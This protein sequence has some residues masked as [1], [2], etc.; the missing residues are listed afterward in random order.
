MTAALEVENLI[1]RAGK[2][3]PT[4]VEG[5]SFTAEPGEILGVVGESGSG[6][7]TLGLAILGYGR[8][9]AV[10]TGGDIRIHGRSM[11][12]SSQNEIRRLRGDAVSYM[13]QDP[14]ASLNPARHIGTQL[15][16]VLELKEG[17]RGRRSFARR[18]AAAM[19]EVHLPTEAAFLRR[20]PH[21]L[22]GG[23][24]QR[25]LLALAFLRDPSVVVLDEPT[26]GLDVTTQARVLET[27]RTMCL[28]RQTVA[29]YISHDLDVVSDLASRMLVLYGGQV[30]EFGATGDLFE[31]PRHRYTAALLASAPELDRRR[32]LV[33]IPGHAP[34]LADRHAGCAFAPRCS[35]ADDACQVRPEATAFSSAHVAHCHHPVP[36]RLAVKVMDAGRAR[37]TPS[38]PS[39]TLTAREVRANYGSVEVLHGVDL[40]VRRG[41]CVAI[42]GESGS[43]KTTLSQCLSGLHPLASGAVAVDGQ[44]LAPRARD[45][46]AVERQAIQYVFQ[47]PYGALNPRKTVRALLE[48][49]TKAFGLSNDSEGWLERVRLGRHVL[50]RRPR[51]LSGGE[52]QRVAIARALMTDPDFLICDEITSA[53]DFSIQASVINLLQSLQEETGIGIVFVTHNL[54]LVASLADRVVVMQHGE[55]VEEGATD[56]VLDTPTTAY[57]KQLLSAVPG[58]RS[59]RRSPANTEVPLIRP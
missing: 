27:V 14:G 13:P 32:P 6:K 25:V 51:Q 57:T 48:Q 38:T 50:S 18:I 19:E 40:K 4:I 35:H 26:T 36:D 43:G 34:R 45:R 55:V 54:P 28:H 53:L 33:G 39:S 42:V 20:Y 21:E 59:A 29:I 46:T 37:A 8:D 30:A 12:H 49:P 15:T 1:V 22:S 11:V 10:I 56:E 44:E 23:Q 31:H 52:R 5:L 2:N 41:E 58:S 16:E 3:G 24:Q 47:N 17:R 7:T 9:G